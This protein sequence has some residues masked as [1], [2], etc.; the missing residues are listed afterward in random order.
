MGN[1]LPIVYLLFLLFLVHYVLPN[2]YYTTQT[3]THQDNYHV[4]INFQSFIIQTNIYSPND[5]PLTKR[6]SSH[7]TTNFTPKERRKHQS[8]SLKRLKP[9]ISEEKQ[10]NIKGF[11]KQTYRHHQTISSSI[12]LVGIR[13]A[14]F[15][16]QQSII[17]IYPL[18]GIN[19]HHS[20]LL[21]KFYHIIDG[22]YLANSQRFL[23]VKHRMKSIIF[24]IT[25]FNQ[26]MYSDILYQRS[27]PLH[28]FTGE[29][30]GKA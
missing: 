10:P 25:F 8:L 30:M 7:Q 2:T 12:F 20:M 28:R 13:W 19:Y 14:I 23:L 1:P 6:P 11:I 22:I 21:V 26:C 17:I 16:L 27:T 18:P 29:A 24:T 15:T 9:K 5:H 4:E 3:K